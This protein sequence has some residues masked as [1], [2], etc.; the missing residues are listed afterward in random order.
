MGV[1]AMKKPKSM[2]EFCGKLFLLLGASFLL[3]GILAKAGVMKMKPGSQGD[4]RGF[5]ILGC[6]F[7]AV[8]VITLPASIFRAKKRELLLQTGTP[9]PGTVVS[10]NQLPFTTWGNSHPYVAHFAYEWEGAQYE[11]KSCL[12]WTLPSVREHDAVTVLV[13]MENPKRCVLKL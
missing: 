5:L 9:V 11:G 6:A 4:L 13:D 3:F 2:W 12:L 1:S 7:L 10:V 8:G